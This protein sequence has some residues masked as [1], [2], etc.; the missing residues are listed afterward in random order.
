MEGN[1]TG[2]LTDIDATRQAYEEQGKQAHSAVPGA[3]GAKALEEI[4]NR[5]LSDF[6][7]AV[8]AALKTPAPNAEAMRW[9]L[10]TLHAIYVDD[11]TWDEID[12]LLPEVL[13]EA[14]QFVGRSS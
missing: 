4:S 14:Q 12:R 5:L 10:A 6:D 13:A 9:K 11:N 7:R 8:E 3:P 2:L 1:W